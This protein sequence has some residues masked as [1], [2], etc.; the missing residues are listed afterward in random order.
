MDNL[1][2]TTY[3]AWSDYIEHGNKKVYKCHKCTCQSGKM[4]QRTVTEPTG[5]AHREYQILCSTCG[6]K[7]G[8]FWNKSMAEYSWEAQGV[9]E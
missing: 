9:I 7:G 4:M 1:N 8:T 5:G 6:N 3:S 2:R